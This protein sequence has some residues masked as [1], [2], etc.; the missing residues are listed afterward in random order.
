MNKEAVKIHC[1]ELDCEHE[2]DSLDMVN[3]L[4][5]V[6]KYIEKDAMA[7]V[8][9]SGIPARDSHLVDAAKQAGAVEIIDQDELEL[10]ELKDSST[11]DEAVTKSFDKAPTTTDIL[12][13]GKIEFHSELPQVVFEKLVG[14]TFLIHDIRIVNDWDGFFGKSDFGLLLLQLRDGRRATT[15]SGGVAVLK[16]LRGFEAFL[17]KRRVPIKVSLTTKPGDNGPYYLFE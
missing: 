15:L 4:Q 16:Q 10:A 5:D 14:H 17:K 3:H 13:T 11:I 12:G 6:H 7:I 2:G 9:P 8:Y 1:P